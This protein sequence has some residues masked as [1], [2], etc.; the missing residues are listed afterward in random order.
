MTEQDKEFIDKLESLTR[1]GK[2]IW[3]QFDTR[4]F[5]YGNGKHKVHL[6]YTFIKVFFDGQEVNII[7]EDESAP[8]NRVR[9]LYNLVNEKY[10]ATDR[11]INVLNEI[12]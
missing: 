3:G 4:G 9:N 8:L 1:D 10:N 6:R 2:I 5:G 11:F 7:G 12:K